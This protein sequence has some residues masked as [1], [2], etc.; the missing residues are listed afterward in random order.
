MIRYYHGDML[1]KFSVRPGI[2]GLA[3]ISGRGRLSFYETVKY[4]VEYVENRSFWLDLK[5]MLSTIKKIITRDG[6][7]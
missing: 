7:F 2:T 5:I 4:D 6:A 3:Q 1:K